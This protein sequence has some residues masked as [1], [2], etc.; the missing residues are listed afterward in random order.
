MAPTESAAPSLPSPRSPL[1]QPPPRHSNASSSLVPSRWQCTAGLGARGGG[2]GPCCQGIPP[3]ASQSW[4]TAEGD[5]MG[6]L[7]EGRAV[8]GP[9]GIHCVQGEEVL[10]PCPLGPV[11]WPRRG[12]HRAPTTARDS[13][14]GPSLL[15]PRVLGAAP[16]PMSRLREAVL[17]LQV[18]LIPILLI[19]P[20]GSGHVA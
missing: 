15:R 20:A 1:P 5:T 16:R 2:H 19:I 6:I 18:F 4:L 12:V 17:T 8:T 10:A 11:R 9:I 3:P 14:A 7:V 13:R